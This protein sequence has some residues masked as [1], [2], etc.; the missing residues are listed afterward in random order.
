MSL[1]SRISLLLAALMAA[2]VMAQETPKPSLDEGTKATV[3][4]EVTS[5]LESVAFVPGVDFDKWDA[6]V[7][8]NEEHLNGA[9]SPEDLAV[10]VNQ[11]FQKF[12]LSHILLF[13][14]VAAERRSTNQM[15]G[16]GVRVQLEEKG[17]RVVRVFA[18]GAAAGAGI[19]P[20][21]L[22]IEADG[23]PIKDTARLSGK[24]G[25]P[26]KLK[27]DRNNVIIEREVVRKKFATIIPEE[28]AWPTREVA[29]VT[30]PSFDA[31]YNAERV[32]ELM[33]RAATAKGIILDLR[34][35]GGGRVINLL[36]LASF[37]LTREQPIGTFVDRN[38]IDKY[39]EQTGAQFSNVVEVAE[40]SKTKVF[41][42]RRN[43]DPFQGKVTVLIDGATGSASEMMA[44]ALQEYKGA[45]I[46]GSKSAGA[47][48]ASTMRPL[49]GGFLL[50]FPLM[51]YVTIKGHRLEGSG[52]VPDLPAPTPRFGEVDQGIEHALKVLTENIDK[53][54]A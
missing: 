44:A 41:P 13:S 9:K 30:V 43:R 11:M 7:Q 53:V 29:H 8:E 38:A 37:F 10:V 16:L 22:I 49:S 50:Q 5:I 32:Q 19:K 52:I 12:G 40:W 4:M 20:G 14:P 26:V 36:H 28:L 42:L 35:N 48:L 25:Q 51:D 6:M 18:E 33:T 3:L 46:I 23:E 47:V 24:E 39:T 31:E 27:I 21:D 2:P 15:V 45:K 34:G 54:A 1:R 17:V